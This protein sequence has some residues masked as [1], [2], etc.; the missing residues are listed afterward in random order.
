MN[1]TIAFFLVSVV[2]KIVVIFIGYCLIEKIRKIFLRKAANVFECNQPFSAII[3]AN[4]P[5]S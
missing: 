5:D 2:K 4:S 3:H 1:K